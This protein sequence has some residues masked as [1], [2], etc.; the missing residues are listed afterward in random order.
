MKRTLFTL[1][2]AGVAAMTA[3]AGVTAQ[4]DGWWAPVAELLPSAEIRQHPVCRDIPDLPACRTTD[5]TRERDT[6][7]ETR[8][9]DGGW[10][11]EASRGQRGAEGRA[12][13]RPNAR[14]GNGPPFCRNGQGHPVHG[15]KWCRDKGWGQD[16]GWRDV[17][18]EDV[19][20]GPRDRRIERTPR[21]DRGGLLDVLGDVVLGRLERQGRDVGDGALTGRFIEGRTRVLQI[22]AGD[23][24]LAE[25]L[26]ADRDGRVDRVLLRTRR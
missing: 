15:T 24:P 8:D 7:P 5:R 14:Q 10:G 11:G 20:L 21:L 19:I 23:V 2:F 18:W 4:D 17:S 3:P 13:R 6:R 22:R 9:R 1:A 12:D 25:L 16:G 26:D